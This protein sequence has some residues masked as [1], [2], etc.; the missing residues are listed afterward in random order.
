M[1]TKLLLSTAIIATL[2]APSANAG[3]YVGA[4]L[5]YSAIS[6]KETADQKDNFPGDERFNGKTKAKLNPRGLQTS[7]IAGYEFNCDK[8]SIA[9]EFEA[10]FNNAKAKKS[11]QINETGAGVALLD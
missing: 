10:G 5:G 3:A 2:A 8:F 7:L 9:P 11:S 4:K 1:K 6:G